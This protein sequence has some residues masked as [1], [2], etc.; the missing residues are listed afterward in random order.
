[1]RKSFLL[2]L[3]N[4][5]LYK[6]LIRYL[7]YLIGTLPFVVAVTAL[8]GSRNRVTEVVILS[9]SIVTAPVIIIITTGLVIFF[10]PKQKD[11]IVKTFSRDYFTWLRRN[12]LHEIITNSSFLNNSL[13]R[14]DLLKFLY[15]QL[16]GLTNPFLIIIAPHVLLLDPDRLICGKETFIGVNSL[17]TG[18][19]IKGDRLLIQ[20]V[21]LG[22]QVKIGSACVISCGVKIG[23]GTRIDFGVSIGTNCKIGR[24]VIILRETKIDDNVTI[25][26]SVVVGKFCKIGRKA[27]IRKNAY[28]ESFEIIKAKQIR[29]DES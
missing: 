29:S 19:I 10:H 1:M 2:T 18:H 4:G 13:N 25:E 5:F 22:H 17:I 27:V 26:D 8:S 3:I 24:N 6:F 23:D 15:Y 7:I 11:G 21:H 20:T 16:A 14:I 9:L 12:L 28:I